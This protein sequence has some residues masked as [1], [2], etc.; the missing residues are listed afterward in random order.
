[1]F[2][3]EPLKLTTEGNPAFSEP[4]GDIGIQLK[5]DIEVAFELSCET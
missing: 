3:V 1:M 2:F 4:E 5:S